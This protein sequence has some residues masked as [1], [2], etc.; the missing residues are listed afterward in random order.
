MIAIFF[1]VGAIVNKYLKDIEF[2]VR[3]NELS[4]FLDLG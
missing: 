1:K 2:E 3:E 4:E